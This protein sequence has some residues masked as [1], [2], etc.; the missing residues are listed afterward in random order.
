MA[1]ECLFAAV[2]GN[3]TGRDGGKRPM[4]IGRCQKMSDQ[5][6][7]TLCDRLMIAAGR[8]PQ[9]ALTQVDVG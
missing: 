3:E 8:S 2:R 1:E 4:A 9:A 5:P 6:H 7:V